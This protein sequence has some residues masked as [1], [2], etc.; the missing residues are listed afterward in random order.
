M[1]ALN[2]FLSAVPMPELQPLSWQLATNAG[3]SVW[4]L[5]LD[6]IH[7]G[8]SG[9]K[10]YKL[11]GHLS[12]PSAD[13]KSFNP[14]QGSASPQPLPLV[15]CGGGYSNHLHA[16]A[17]LGKALHIPTIGVVRG[18]YPQL[19]PTLEDCQAWGM[20]LLFSSRRQ[21]ALKDNP[22]QFL[23]SLERELNSDVLVS[24]D[25]HYWIPEGGG[26][27]PG[28]RGCR[29]IGE[30]L[31]QHA[32]GSLAVSTTHP[33]IPVYL[34]CGTGTTAAGLISGLNESFQVE[35]ISVLKG[36]DQLTDEITAY[37]SEAKPLSDSTQ[38]HCP[39]RIHTEFHD[40]GYGK[41]SESLKAFA[42]QFEQE[43]ALQ[44]DPIYTLKAFWALSH[45]LRQKKWRANTSVVVVHT[46]GLQGRRGMD[47]L[48]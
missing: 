12:S 43:T 39:W 27:L 38:S 36:E 2:H 23:A 28:V 19:T 37:L 17:Y 21:W 9:N 33:R 11:F 47:W 26:G 44:L 42:R 34:A 16:L 40:G 14:Q 18:F 13:G 25:D 5:R 10:W 22:S 8:W 29:L 15:S 20:R 32:Q 3:V 30:A 46:G 1:H 35:G 7:Q 4:V 45:H 41:A 24:S 6:Q 31:R 48:C